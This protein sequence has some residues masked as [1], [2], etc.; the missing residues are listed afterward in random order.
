MCTP[1]KLG[2]VAGG[3]C[4]HGRGAES[5]AGA[6][7]R[8]EVVSEHPPWA[9]RGES[10]CKS[11]AHTRSGRWSNVGATALQT[12]PPRAQA[13]RRA[14]SP[15]AAAVCQLQAPGWLVTRS[16]SSAAASQTPQPQPTHTPPLKP[17]FPDAVL[18]LCSDPAE[19]GREAAGEATY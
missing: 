16:P 6:P 9:T 7:L 14:A 2:M 3:Q 10:L 8:L 5:A 19:E 17:Y 11:R 13:A 4:A 18:R 12:P 1:K 15:A